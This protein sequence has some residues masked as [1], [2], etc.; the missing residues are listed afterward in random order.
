MVCGDDGVSPSQSPGAVRA[1]GAA[2][3]LCATGPA[4]SRE[5]ALALLRSVCISGSVRG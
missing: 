1:Q 2:A 4:P 5:K 3:L